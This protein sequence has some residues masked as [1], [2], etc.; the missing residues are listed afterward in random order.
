MEPAVRSPRIEP[1]ITADR[2]RKVRF[3]PKTPKIP[4]LPKGTGAVAARPRGTEF[5]DAETGGSNRPERPQRVTGDRKS[6]TTPAKIPTETA[7]SGS[8][9]KSE[10]WY[11]WMVE[12]IGIE[13]V[14]PEQVSDYHSFVLYLWPYGQPLSLAISNR[15]SSSRNRRLSTIFL[16]A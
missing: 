8:A 16:F 6:G 5:L 2:L 12:A 1:A 3:G 10:V 13:P 7:C 4:G 15:R 14:T 11:D 9:W